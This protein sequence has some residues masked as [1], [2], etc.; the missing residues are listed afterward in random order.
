MTQESRRGLGTLGPVRRIVCRGQGKW[1]CERCVTRYQ[2][3]PGDCPRCIDE[4]LLNLDVGAV[5]E[6][7][8]ELDANRARQRWGQAMGASAAIVIVVLIANGLFGTQTLRGSARFGAVAMGGLAMLL[9]GLF[10]PQQR[11]PLAK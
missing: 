5:R 9:V 8:E 4:P 2:E 7:L 3:G 10:P 11:N 6:L 1:F